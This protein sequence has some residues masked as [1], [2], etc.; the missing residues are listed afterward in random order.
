MRLLYVC[1]DPGIP[2]AGNKGASVHLRAITAALQRRGHQVALLVRN[3]SGDNPMPEVSLVGDLP[4]D[5]T[6]AQDRIAEVISDSKADAVI[7][8]YSLKSGPARKATLSLSV[9]FILEVNAPLVEEAQRYRG[10]DDPL[11]PERE[12]QTLRGADRIHVVSPALLRYVQ[13]VAPAVPAC[14]IPNGVDLDT[15]D[16]AAAAEVPALGPGPVLGF[17]G[18][19]KPWH[20]VAEL[21]E[22]FA[23][24]RQDIPDAYLLLVGGGPEE[25]KLRR[26][27]AAGDL[28]GSVVFTGAVHHSEV[29]ALI[30]RMDLAV[31]P[32]L[33]Q[34]HF[35][36]QPMKVMEYLAAGVPVLYSDQ[37]NL[38]EVVD[39][40]GAPF[41]AGSVPDM[42]ARIR[43]NLADR[44]RM[45]SLARQ[46]TS[47]AAASSWDAVAERLVAWA[48]AD[49][50]PA[51]F[52]TIQVPS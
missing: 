25:D 38:A 1:A 36:F 49:V 20:G 28:A 2:L 12:R 47:R 18:S 31:A 34:P 4:D 27:A 22:A 21:L 30:K 11:A 52:S 14:C 8:R 42:A 44:T 33:P 43:E 13:Q 16:V 32:Y 35:Y 24:V 37:G 45:A 41:K 50:P 5:P 10:L 23:L 7:E 39:A 9:P 29:P 15:F 17:V 6:E 19:M 40:G 51:T 3:T 46:A 48:T 26:R